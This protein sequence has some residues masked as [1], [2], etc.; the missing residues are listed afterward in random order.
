MSPPARSASRSAASSHERR[1]G[2]IHQNCALL[3]QSKLRRAY[4]ADGFRRKNQ[5]QGNHVGARKQLL[6]LDRFGGGVLVRKG[7]FE[8]DDSS[9]RFERRPVGAAMRDS[10]GWG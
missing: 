4:D 1:P 6:L 2:G 3:Q 9:P 8:E 7:V 10:S 5:V